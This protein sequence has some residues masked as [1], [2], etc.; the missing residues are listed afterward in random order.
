MNAKTKSL[1]AISTLTLIQLS[2]ACMASD[3]SQHSDSSAAVSSD[4]R[5]VKSLEEDDLP[6]EDQAHQSALEVV[7][8]LRNRVEAEPKDLKWESEIKTLLDQ[9]W[10]AN[11][12]L[13]RVTRSTQVN[14]GSTICELLV[15][16]QY[17]AEVSYV[18]QLK[19]TGR[20]LE[21]WKGISTIGITRSGD[22][23]N[24]T[25]KVWVFFHNPIDENK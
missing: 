17:E 7:E 23:T 18:R 4:A 14:C 1:F 12:D 2:A 11:N 25:H 21:L 8:S 15:E 16:V 24:Q 5:S 6:S 20:R 22:S 3:D 19:N 9:E 13:S 10:K